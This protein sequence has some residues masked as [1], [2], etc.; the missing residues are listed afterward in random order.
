MNNE[1]CLTL[2]KNASSALQQADEFIRNGV[3]LGYIQL[4]PC[5]VPDPANL[6]PVLISQALRELKVALQVW[7]EISEVQRTK[8]E[9][10]QTEI[11]LLRQDNEAL[12]RNLRGSQS[13][14]GATYS[15]LVAER[16]ALR[17]E[18][19]SSTELLDKYERVIDRLRRELLMAQER[20][21]E[22]HG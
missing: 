4:P 1:K 21:E 5:H 9:E 22:L 12:A 3:E 8:E 16:D 17:E 2:L 20:K 10:L 14:T 7:S 13:T 15:H 6:T 11:S 19:T 18:A